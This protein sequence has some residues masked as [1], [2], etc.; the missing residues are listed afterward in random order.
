M[1][2]ISKV[3]TCLA[4]GI[5]IDRGV[6]TKDTYVYPIV[7]DL[8]NITN[9]QNLE[10]VKQWK[11]WHL[12]TYSCGYPTQMFSRK[13]IQD[14]NPK[15]FL[16]YLF[17]YDL[18]YEPGERYVYNNA[19]TYILSVIIQL[20]TGKNL[21]KFVEEEIFVPLNIKS[22]EWKDY[23]DYCAGGTG[24]LLS[25]KDMFKVAE[26]IFNK[27]KFDG[28]QLISQEYITTMCSTQIATPYDTKPERVLPKYGVGYIMHI[29]RDGF[30]FKD[31]TNGQ[32]IILNPDKNLLITILAS[33]TDMPCVLEILRGLV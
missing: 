23:G 31:G 14:K 2:S 1:R 33:E 6:I 11:I 3:L 9:A 12:L 28:K 25:H 15:E 19:E 24:L 16:D 7:K 32:Y 4:C 10:K 27:G 22:Y 13:F 26:L 30:A 18:S 17:N 8:V 5:L 21:S 20:L 29:S